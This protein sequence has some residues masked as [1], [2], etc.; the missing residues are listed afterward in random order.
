M[1]QYLC[2]HFYQSLKLFLIFRERLVCL[3][4][5]LQIWLLDM[6]CFI[7]LMGALLVVFSLDFITVFLFLIFILPTILIF[8]I[9]LLEFGIAFL[10]A[11]VFSVLF[12]IYLTDSCKS[13]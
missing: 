13:H 4:D 5:F 2:Y 6:L 3:F 8:S 9:T 12:L 7:F 1:S 11:Y 10:Q